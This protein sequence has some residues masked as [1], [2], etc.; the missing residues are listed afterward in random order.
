VQVDAMHAEI[1]S[2]VISVNNAL[3]KYADELKSI[4]GAVSA[5]DDDMSQLGKLRALRNLHLPTHDILPHRTVCAPLTLASDGSH[6][7]Q[8]SDTLQ[9][10]SYNVIVRVTGY[11]EVSKTPFQRTQLATILVED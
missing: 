1:I 10:G 9:A 6:Q 3:L 7:L 8:V 2:P 4:S 11:S 5:S